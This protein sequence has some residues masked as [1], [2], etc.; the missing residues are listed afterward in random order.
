M[1]LDR[2]PEFG[3]CSRRSTGLRVRRRLDKTGVKGG[4]AEGSLEGPDVGNCKERSS[5]IFSNGRLSVND[6]EWTTGRIG[7][8]IG[9]EMGGNG[10]RY[11][12]LVCC[13]RRWGGD[14]LSPVVSAAFGDDNGVKV[15]FDVWPSYEDCGSVD[16]SAIGS[17]EKPDGKG[18][19]ERP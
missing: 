10:G 11:G 7:R 12:G 14:F 13:E 18:M 9:G 4:L 2:L 19:D 8:G 1:R 16:D 5:M 15:F 3:S 6:K 17:L